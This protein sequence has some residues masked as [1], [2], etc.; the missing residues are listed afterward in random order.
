MFDVTA[1]SPSRLMNGLKRK[2]VFL[3]YRRCDSSDMIDRLDERLVHAFGRTRVTRD[4]VTIPLGADFRE[5]IEFDIPRQSALLA[6][7]GP[8]W[9]SGSK[10]ANFRAIDDPLDL[11][12]FEIECALKHRIR[13]IPVIVGNARMPLRDELPDKI[14]CLAGRHALT[15]RGDPD[16]HGDVDRLIAAV[17]E[18]DGRW[19]GR[20]W[21]RATLN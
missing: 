1:A 9:L 4:L 5:Y 18:H 13:V 17:R 2:R 11:V 21:H 10:A 15:L 7:I 6:V 19:A 20:G 14:A 3:S 12:R 16:F 8:F